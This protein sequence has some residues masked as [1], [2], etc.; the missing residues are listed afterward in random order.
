LVHRVKEV[1][2]S[3]ERCALASIVGSVTPSA[4]TPGGYCGLGSGIGAGVTVTA[5]IA[6]LTD[7]S[8]TA[9]KN[10]EDTEYTG[11]RPSHS[12]ERDTRTTNLF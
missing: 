7:E 11:R 12:F 4:A 1:F 2:V 3:P 10:H 8:A 9:R 5:P 6:V